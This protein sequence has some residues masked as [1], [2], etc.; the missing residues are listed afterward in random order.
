MT[1]KSDDG[2]NKDERS[3]K[4]KEPMMPMPRQ[5]IIHLLLVALAVLASTA[6]SY[7]VGGDRSNSAQLQ[8]RQVASSPAPQSSGGATAEAP[9]P[10]ACV[11][12]DLANPIKDIYPMNATGVL[13][14]TLTI[15]P[16]TMEAARRIIP[17][18]YAILERPLRAALPDFP[19]GM[20]P[21]LLQAAHDHDV[22]LHGLGFTLPDFSVRFACLACLFFF[23]FFCVCN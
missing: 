5:T 21:V 13:N 8:Q 19:E 10:A 6:M 12:V 4:Y 9:A 3:N 7:A 11:S 17:A 22:G 14:A 23:F 1:L 18:K 2:N 16:I 20:Y 15:L